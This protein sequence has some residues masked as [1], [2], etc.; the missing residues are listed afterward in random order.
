[1]ERDEHLDDGSLWEVY[2]AINGMYIRVRRFYLA[3]SMYTI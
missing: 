2:I 1:M 3:Q